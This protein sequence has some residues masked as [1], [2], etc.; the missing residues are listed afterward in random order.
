MTSGFPEIPAANLATVTGCNGVAG[1]MFPTKSLYRP[2]VAWIA[3]SRRPC[4]K[5]M[6]HKRFHQFQQSLAVP[7]KYRFYFCS[8]ASPVQVLSVSLSWIA[9]FSRRRADES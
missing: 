7:A 8:Q 2:I 4:H 1:I 6:L 9:K 5:T 3:T